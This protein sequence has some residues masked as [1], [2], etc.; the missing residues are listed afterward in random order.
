MNITQLFKNKSTLWITITAKEKHCVMRQFFRESPQIVSL[1]FPVSVVFLLSS[2]AGGVGLNLI[3]A[4]RLVLYDID[5]NPANDLQVN[6]MA[7]EY[8][9]SALGRIFFLYLYK[10]A[11]R[12][13]K[14]SAH[15]HSSA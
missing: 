10:Y 15:C 4:S 12:R 5:W 7:I 8:R 11:V 9:N 1:C 3:G 13:L 2:K 6:S 14:L